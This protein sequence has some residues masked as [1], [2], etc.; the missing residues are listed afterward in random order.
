VLEE[1]HPY[2][3]GG[4]LAA[5][6]F[7][8]AI[9]IPGVDKFFTIEYEATR[10]GQIHYGRGYDD[11]YPVAFFICIITLIRFLYT[12]VV[13]KPI[14][15]KWNMSVGETVKF[16]EAGWFAIY[17]IIAT[18]WGFC[19]FSDEIWWFNSRYLWDGY[20]HAIDLDMKIFYLSSLAFWLQSL[21]SFTFE[22][23]RKDNAVLCFHHFLTLG[24]IIT[25]YL[26]GF[27]RVGAA[28]MTQQNVGDILF[29]QAK[30]FKYTKMDKTANV[31]WVL[32]LIVWVLT[33][34]LVFGVIIYSFWQSPQYIPMI[35]SPEQEIYLNPTAFWCYLAA[36]LALQALMIFWLS[37]ILKVLFKFL[38]GSGK[39]EDSTEYSDDEV[40]NF[41]S[42]SDKQYTKKKE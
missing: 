3:A 34:H 19:I 16:V 9:R 18:T 26:A 36:V 33:R 23:P 4:I 38:T 42:D 8:K 12:A 30:I 17:Y 25:S 28:I 21:M 27:V 5:L 15:R 41:K 13:L 31:T 37:M 6:L 29:Y 1:Y 40:E 35:W 20:P 11:L 22:P 10:H 39:M 2:V 14:A 7:G 24:L 32:F